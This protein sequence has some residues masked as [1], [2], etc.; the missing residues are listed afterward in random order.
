MW[1]KTINETDGIV[2]LIDMIPKDSDKPAFQAITDAAR[3]SFL[4]ESKGYEK[5]KKLLEYLI[6]HKHDSPLEMVSMKFFVRAPVLVWWQCVRHRHF[7][8]NFQS[9][10][11]VQFEENDFYKPLQWRKQSKDNKQG[12]DG[13]IENEQHILS[14][15]N[16]NDETLSDLF[17]NHYRDSHAI[18]KTLIDN[19]VAKEMARLFLPFLATQYDAIVFG[20]LRAWLHFIELRTGNDAQYEIRLYAN[21]IKECI[22]Y[23]IPELF[24]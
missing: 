23:Y 17:E 22:Q 3:V 11:Y 24:G 4:G 5:D 14:L 15:L 7:S 16:S 21:A 2:K 13:R 12:S 18:Y 8:Y 6:A 20:N 19:G 10:R 1:E 9:G